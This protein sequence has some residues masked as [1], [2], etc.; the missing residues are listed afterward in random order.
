MCG[1]KYWYDYQ[2]TPSTFQTKKY[3]AIASIMR[4]DSVPDPCKQKPTERAAFHEL[5][6]FVARWQYVYDYG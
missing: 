6:I 2:K 1:I 3:N 4:T 5:R